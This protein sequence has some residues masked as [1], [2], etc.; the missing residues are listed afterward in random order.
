MVGKSLMDVATD[1]YKC[2]TKQGNFVFEVQV[3]ST[4]VSLK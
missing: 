2:A 4:A 1:E 3:S